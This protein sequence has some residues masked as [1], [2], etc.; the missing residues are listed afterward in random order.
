MAL[1]QVPTHHKAMQCVINAAHVK[2]NR[3]NAVRLGLGQGDGGMGVIARIE[4]LPHLIVNAVLFFLL[5]LIGAVVAGIWHDNGSF[6]LLEQGH[7]A[8]GSC[9]RV[10]ECAGKEDN[11]FL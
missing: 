5:E 2:V 3:M 11:K 1:L 7:C 6:D 10:C 9:E 4:T 8:R